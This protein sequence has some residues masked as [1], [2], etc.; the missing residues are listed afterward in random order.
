VLALA[1]GLGLAA[2][3]AAV[4]VGG[5][6]EGNAT[7]ACAAARPVAERLA[8]LATGEVAAFAVERRPVPAPDLAFRDGEG[9]ETRLSALR[10]KAVLLN[11]WA[12]WCAPCR[13]EMPALDRLE[14][15]LGGPA[16]AV[17]PISID[18]GSDERPRAFYRETGLQRLA[19]AHDPSGRVFQELRAAGRAVGMPTTVLVDAQGCILGHLSGPAE[20]SSPDALRLVRAALGA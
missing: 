2:G 1:A 13:H 5:G 8:P 6:F 18:L 16:F 20:W 12:T 9:R 3:T 15:E 4:Y 14:A 11:L 17:L 19:F 10:G 7:R